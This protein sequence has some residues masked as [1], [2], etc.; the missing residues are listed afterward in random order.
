ML[1][2]SGVYAQAR[3]SNA[4]AQ[5]TCGVADPYLEDFDVPPTGAV[6]FSLVAGVTGG[7]EGD[8]GTNSAGATRPNTNPCP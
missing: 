1:K 5:R 4:L 7:V 6:K 2:S 8:L 3:G